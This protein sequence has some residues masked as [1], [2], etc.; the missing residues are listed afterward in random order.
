[1][2]AAS[3]ASLALRNWMCL[4]AIVTAAAATTTVYAALQDI[5]SALKVLTD[6]PVWMRPACF[7]QGLDP[8]N[9]ATSKSWRA[10]CSTAA[11]AA[12]RGCPGNSGITNAQPL[13][14]CS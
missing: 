12:L 2:T 13:Y 6:Q 9:E 5:L 8:A 14:K 7:E 10:L 11:K 4:L 1:M 3:A